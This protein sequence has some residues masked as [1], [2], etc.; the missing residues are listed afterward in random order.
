MLRR[1]GIS[2]L[3]TLSFERP[4]LQLAG[5]DVQSLA[6]GCDPGGG[7]A[8]SADHLATATAGWDGGPAAPSVPRQASM[9]P[10]LE[11]PP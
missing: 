3:E 6:A 5:L 8:G 1:L 11:A 9:R 10:R 7:D 2:G 4:H